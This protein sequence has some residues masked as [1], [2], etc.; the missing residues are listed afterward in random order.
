MKSMKAILASTALVAALGLSAASA[1]ASPLV[2]GVRPNTSSAFTYTD[3]WTQTTD[4][5][6]SVGFDPTRPVNL[7]FPGIGTPYLTHFSFQSTIGTMANNGDLV[8]PSWLNSAS[9]YEISLQTKIPEFVIAEGVIGTNGYAGFYHGED[10]SAIVTWYM[11]NLSDGT[12]HNPNAVSG[13]GLDS[14]AVVL[15]TA[16]LLSL[17]S[18]YTANGTTP[19]STGTG[20]YDLKWK[21][22]SYD[23]DLLD[24]GSANELIL[25]SHFTGTTNSPPFYHP[26]TTWDGVS[27]ALPNITLKIDGSEEF[28]EVPEP[29]TMLLLGFGFAG[30]GM[31]GF[32][33]RKKA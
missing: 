12:K 29:S 24:F 18:S 20:S 9:G 11:D 30:L 14:G 31:L 19:L 7:P 26:S 25:G 3:L 33:R 1:Y 15:M 10:T 8:T 22:D 27:T 32:G 23:H 17:S 6:V 28:A 5:G 2:V 13:Y 4:T 16:H 21:I